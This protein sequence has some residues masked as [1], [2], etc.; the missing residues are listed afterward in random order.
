MTQYQQATLDEKI[1]L[2]KTAR[3][4]LAIA[5]GDNAVLLDEF[6]KNNPVYQANQNITE[7]F[8]VEVEAL[9]SEI[10]A[11]ALLLYETDPEKKSLQHPSVQVKIFKV[12]SVFDI[13]MV[14]NWAFGNLPAALVVDMPKIEK[15]AKDF[16]SVD[17]VSVILQPRAQI[18][19]KL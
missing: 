4:N 12:C 6:K 7:I 8:S 11:E 18:S 2:L 15:Y 3:T 1:A 17:G 10:R 9:E 5:K 16:G 13:E 19:T 14:R